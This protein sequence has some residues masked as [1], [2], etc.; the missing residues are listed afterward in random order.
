MRRPRIK[1]IRG[2]GFYHI[3]GRIG[4]RRFLL[5]G[6]P[7]R[8][9]LLGAIRAA[10]GFAGI[11]LYAYAIMSNHFHLL[12]RVPQPREVSDRE[13]NNRLLLLYGPGKFR[14][15]LEKWADWKTRGQGLKGSDPLRPNDTDDNDETF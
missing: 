5:E 14:K 3:V 7:E 6:E 12:A 1:Q 9:S 15:V 4:G 8:K 10:A 11:D 13:L 2:D